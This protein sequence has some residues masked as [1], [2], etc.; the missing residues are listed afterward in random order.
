MSTRYHG[1]V[2]K[3]KNFMKRRAGENIPNKDRKN[4]NIRKME[5]WSKKI[6]HDGPLFVTR[7]TSDYRQH[8]VLSYKQKKLAE[9]SLTTKRNVRNKKNLSEHVLVENYFDRLCRFNLLVSKGRWNAWKY[10]LFL[11]FE[12]VLTDEHAI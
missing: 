1:S 10:S 9:G 11:R 3:I 2:S 6:L 8:I 5:N 7:A 12:T 4:L